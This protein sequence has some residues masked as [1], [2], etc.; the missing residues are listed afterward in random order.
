MLILVE[1]VFVL[2]LYLKIKLSSLSSDYFIINQNVFEWKV[3]AFFIDII[4]EITLEYDHHYS[5][6]GI[7][8]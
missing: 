5:E 8:F 4:H 2:L 6:I 7:V 3:T 1:N